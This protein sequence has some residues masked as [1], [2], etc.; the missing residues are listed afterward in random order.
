MRAILVDIRLLSRR[1]HGKR[2]SSEHAGG[3]E[4]C[5]STCVDVAC[6]KLRCTDDV[7]G[8]E[9]KRGRPRRGEVGASVGP[10]V[11][12]FGISIGG[13]EL[14]REVGVAVGHGDTGDDVRRGLRGDERDDSEQ[15]ET[16][17]NA[18]GRF[19]L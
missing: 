6:R 11:R 10:G 12:A 9:D 3:G 5:R 13:E 14:M 4:C 2:A 7:R 16:G 8:V 1:A 15:W 19:K 18:I 17:R